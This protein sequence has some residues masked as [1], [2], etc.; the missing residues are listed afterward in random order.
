MRVRGDLWT[1]NDAVGGITHEVVGRM[2]AA[3]SNVVRN[4]QLR[5]G[6][7]R[8][9]R[10]AITPAVRF[11]FRRDVFPLGSDEAPDFVALQTP[12]THVANVF[13][14]VSS[15]CTGHVNEQLGN[16]VDRN[17]AEP[18]RGPEAVSLDQHPD[19]L[20]SLRKWQP[21][22]DKHNIQFVIICQA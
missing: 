17:V 1:A 14:V 19:D 8:R 9:P 20:D 22:H 7:N 12:D 21:V 4:A 13:M 2:L 10:P 6:I 3:I 11:L 16:G 18:T 5:I 15:G